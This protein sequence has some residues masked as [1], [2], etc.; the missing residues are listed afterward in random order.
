M[1]LALHLIAKGKIITSSVC[2]LFQGKFFCIKAVVKMLLKPTS[3][4]L[5]FNKKKINLK[6]MN[7]RL[8][9]YSEWSSQK[10]DFMCNLILN[11]LNFLTV[12][13]DANFTHKFTTLNTAQGKLNIK[14]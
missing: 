12:N 9:S 10:T 1:L 4:F 11:T 6:G 5:L 13:N 3:H 7:I 14:T 2:I 8:L